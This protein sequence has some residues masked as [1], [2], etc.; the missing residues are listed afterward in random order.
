GMVVSHEVEAYISVGVDPIHHLAVPRFLGVTISLVMLN[1]YFSVFGL[2]GS[3]LV[4]QFFTFTPV[5]VYFGSLLNQ[6]SIHDVS[7]SIIKSIAFGMIISTVAVI[8]GF[9]VERAF[10][11]VPVAGLKAVSGAFGLC[12][13]V[14]VLLSVLFFVV[15]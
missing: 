7:L 3:F 15:L 9:S 4:S 2:A 11:E 5:D 6:L 8:Q 12:I 1:I 10:T 13:F 14:N